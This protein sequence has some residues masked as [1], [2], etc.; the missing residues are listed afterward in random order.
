MPPSSPF[1]AIPCTYRDARFVILRL[2]V[3]EG[4]L[5]PLL[6]EPLEPTG[7]GLCLVTT[8]AWHAIKLHNSAQ[9]VSNPRTF[10]SPGMPAA[11]R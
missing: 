10:L 1:F 6:P 3:P 7:S 2:R 5:A 9:E 8:V 4:A 11:S